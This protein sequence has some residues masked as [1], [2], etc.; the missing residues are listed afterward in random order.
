M[1]R[2]VALA[3]LAAVLG[4]LGPPI[5]LGDE[6]ITPAN[7][8]PPTANEWTEPFATEFSLGAAVRFLDSAAL[9]WQAQRQCMTCHTNYAY[10]LARPLISAA[11]P[12]HA[13]V[14][15][16]GEKLVTE[17]WPSQGPRWDAEVVCSATTLALN[18]ALTTRKL[19]AVTRAALDRVWTVQRE[20]GGFDWIKCGWP[21]MESDDHYGATFAAIGVGAA[22][23]KYAETPAAKAGL[24]KIRGYLKKNPSPTAHHRAM[25]LWA[26]TYLDGFLS[27]AEK[28]ACIG[29][30]LGLQR[31]DG[32]WALASLGDWKRADG[33]SQDPETSDGYGTG[34]V[35]YVLRRAGLPAEHP[36][37]AAGVRWLKSHQRISGRWF[38]RSLNRDNKHFIT[39][40]GTAF[41]VMALAECGEKPAAEAVADHGLTVG[42]P[43]D[44]GMD[45]APLAE[46]GKRMSQFVEQ[47]QAAGVVTLVAR[48]GRI[49]HHEAVGLADI[50]NK[51]PMQKDTIFGIAS[52]TKPITAAAVM[53]LED[54]G[55]LSID[56]PVSKY[57]PAFKDAAL[58][59]GRPK[60]EVT[61]RDVLTHTSGLGGSQQN[62]GTLE[63][64]VEKLARRKL[65]FEPGAKWQ[66]SPGLTVA[67]RVVEVVSGKPFDVFL[68]ERFFEPLKMVDTSF[69]PTPQ[70]QKRLA[71]LYQPSKDKQSLEPTTH[72]IIDL[73][74]GRTP[75]PSGGLFSTASDMARWYQ[76]IL[77]GGQLDGRRI[78]SEKSVREMTRVQTGEL[79]VGFTDGNGWGL[80]FCVVRKP[81]GATKMLSPGTYGHGGALGTQGWVD[82]KREMILVLM[83]QR[84]NFGNSD[85][86]DLRVA[87]QELAV[88]AAKP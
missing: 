17:R 11:A 36:R 48:R 13:A 62:E 73:S 2:A 59:D 81:Q 39:H 51:L 27:E 7:Y 31:S 44:V 16:Y 67:G 78:L 29:E 88:Q 21:P 6:P 75:N 41:A 52:M 28:R 3:L 35:I 5:A 42:K 22:P 66:Y 25:V 80:G 37:L 19:H 20:D 8:S 57:I 58:K 71:R 74:E 33:K 69:H 47:K 85:A 49:V 1:F 40:A 60:R 65:D 70:Q 24:E 53:V 77:N 32:G 56:D 43:A 46:I 64:T 9:D 82:P 84:T 87:L 26:S 34:F 79:T 45:E 15:E 30:L 23:E 68:R 61:I 10:L 86:S 18:D 4:G 38:T 55:K 83:I 76:M 63:E 12:A 14:R 72:W 54:E 50:E